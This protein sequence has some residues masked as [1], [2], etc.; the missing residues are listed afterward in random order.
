MSVIV[1][2]KVNLFKSVIVTLKVNLLEA[3]QKLISV[4]GGLVD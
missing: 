1:T 2:L 4:W 3:V